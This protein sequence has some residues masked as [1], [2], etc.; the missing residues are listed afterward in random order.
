MHLHTVT[1]TS[2]CTVRAISVINP[3]R[4]LTREVSSSMWGH[5]RQGFA[6]LMERT[7]RPCQVEQIPTSSLPIPINTNKKAP[8]ANGW[9]TITSELHQSTMDFER[10]RIPRNLFCR[11]PTLLSEESLL[12]HRVTSP[13]RLVTSPR[14]FGT[15][16]KKTTDNSAEL[17]YVLELGT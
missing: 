5:W 6:T 9:K 1:L 8:A 3:W 10:C 17:D 12:M 15:E 11:T 2:L 14:H 16:C 4:T 13:R 7:V